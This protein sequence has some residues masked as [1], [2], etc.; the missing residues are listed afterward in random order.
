[1]L[2]KGTVVPGRTAQAPESAEGEGEAGGEG[3]GEC[4]GG[5]TD[6]ADPPS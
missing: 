4:E 1:M 5:R 6:A 3:E 2:T